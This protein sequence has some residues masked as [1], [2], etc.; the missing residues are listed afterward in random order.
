MQGQ[1]T[2]RYV[3]E[4]LTLQGTMAGEDVAKA[5]APALSAQLAAAA[6]A[7]A[8][9]QLEAEPSGFFAVV[10]REKA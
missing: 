2:E 3:A 4:V 9:L 6:A 5:I 10:A 7:Y 8:S 1:A